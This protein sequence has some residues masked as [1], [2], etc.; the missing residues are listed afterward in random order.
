MNTSACYGNR[1]RCSLANFD[2]HLLVVLVCPL[3]GRGGKILVWLQGIALL[4]A[5]IASQGK[6]VDAET[7]DLRCL[8]SYMTVVADARSPERE[9]A[10]ISA[11]FFVGRIFNRHADID[12]KAALNHPAVLHGTGAETRRICDKTLAE[13]APRM[14]VAF[15]NLREIFPPNL[16]NKFNL[17]I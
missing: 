5:M 12:L 1:S 3:T 17:F 9:N 14:A 8:A 15:S 10:K 2:D 11:S 7:Q 13:I 6:A 4:S 16:V